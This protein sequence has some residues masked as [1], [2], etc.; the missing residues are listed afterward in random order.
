MTR[1]LSRERER[2]VVEDLEM[3]VFCSFCC[4]LSLYILYKSNI[5]LLLTTTYFVVVVLLLFLLL[6]VR[7]V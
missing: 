6:R 4:I 5:I 2:E 3:I 1:F 7:R